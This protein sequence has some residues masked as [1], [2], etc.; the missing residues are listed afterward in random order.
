M[1]RTMSPFLPQHRFTC[2][3]LLR[4]IRRRESQRVLRKKGEKLWKNWEN[5]QNRRASNR[6]LLL[7]MHQSRHLHPPAPPDHPRSI[8]YDGCHPSLTSQPCVVIWWQHRNPRLCE[9]AHRRVKIY[10]HFQ[11][12]CRLLPPLWTQVP[13]LWCLQSYSDDLTSG[14]IFQ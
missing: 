2:T 5:V 12:A 6:L 10:R 3:H 13:G 9:A 14:A 7:P 1:S 4:L 8:C 11:N